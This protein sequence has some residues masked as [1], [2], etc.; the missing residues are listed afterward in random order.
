M[1]RVRELE[2]MIASSQTI[3][4]NSAMEIMNVVPWDRAVTLV[5]S[6]AAYTLIPRSDGSL[7]RSQFLSVPRPLVVSLNHYVPR[8]HVRQYTNDSAVANEVIHSR[9]NYTCQYCGTKVPRKEATVDHILPRS[10]GGG[11]TWGN[12]CT[13]CHKCNNKKGNKTPEEAGMITPVIPDWG[14]ANKGKIMQDALYE[15]VTEAWE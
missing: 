1:S 14:S 5:V 15:I 9:D 2:K 12:L 6:N 10:R 7:I 4:V 13:A 8:H 3:V 11:S